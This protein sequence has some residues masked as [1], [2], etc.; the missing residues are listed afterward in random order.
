M[1]KGEQNKCFLA[2]LQITQFDIHPGHPRK[3]LIKN[4]NELMVHRLLKL[5]LVSFLQINS[6]TLTF[7]VKGRKLLQWYRSFILVLDPG[8]WSPAALCSHWWTRP[9]ITSMF[10]RYHRVSRVLL[11]HAPLL[12]LLLQ[13]FP[14]ETLK[15]WLLD[16][17][18]KAASCSWSFNSK[19]TQ[20]LSTLCS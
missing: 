4:P 9:Y 8:R 11:S 15:Q 18:V 7:W 14:P 13:W 10:T 2:F 17:R 5:V 1:L 3:D 12:L 6:S 16:F 19:I 20:A